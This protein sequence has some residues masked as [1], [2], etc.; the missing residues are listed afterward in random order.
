LSVSD[1]YFTSQQV[2]SD[3]VDYDWVWA[4]I[5]IGADASYR[6]AIAQ[7]SDE[8]E[9]LHIF[10]HLGIEVALEDVTHV[11]KRMVGH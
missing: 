4:Y 3:L 7:S 6:M 8:V 2:T 11:S 9:G 10:D 5:T 1:V